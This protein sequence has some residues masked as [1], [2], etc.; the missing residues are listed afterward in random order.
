LK[1]DPHFGLAHSNLAHALTQVGRL[2]EAIAQ[3]EQA[4]LVNPQDHDA[5]ANL[6][7]LKTQL[8]TP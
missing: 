4:L 8:Q 6:T 5:R 3:Y 7:K 1:Y 2:Q